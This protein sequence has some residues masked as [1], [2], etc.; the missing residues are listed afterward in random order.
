MAK[1][2]SEKFVYNNAENT[3][4]LDDLGMKNKEIV[5]Y[6]NCKDYQRFISRI[7]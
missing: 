2:V 4:M 3:K 6:D 1:H 7:I 5:K